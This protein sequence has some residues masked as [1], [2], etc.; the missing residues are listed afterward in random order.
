MERGF[1]GVVYASTTIG[2]LSSQTLENAISLGD[3]QK[4]VLSFP[5]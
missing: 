3:L 1:C 5:Y 4:T 2:G